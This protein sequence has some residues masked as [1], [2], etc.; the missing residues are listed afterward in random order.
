MNRRTFTQ[1]A[2]LASAFVAAGIPRAFAQAAPDEGIDY[3]MLREAV[4]TS[5]PGKIEVLEFLVRMSALLSLGA[6][7]GPLEACARPGCCF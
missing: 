2:A 5:S 1:A 4:P 3:R 6:A 7:S